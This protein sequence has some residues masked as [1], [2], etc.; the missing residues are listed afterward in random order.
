MLLSSL[1]VARVSEAPHAQRRQRRRCAA[2]A[3]A[4][5]RAAP[6]VASW[7]ARAADA[8][9][10]ASGADAPWNVGI[11]YTKRCVRPLRLLRCTIRPPVAQRRARVDGHKLRCVR[12][13]PCTARPVHRT[14]AIGGIP[15]ESMD[16]LVDQPSWDEVRELAHNRLT[17]RVCARLCHR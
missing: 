1:P 7:R 5:R 3:V 16:N 13:A 9:A 8:D 14:D 15:E 12:R 4:Q 6:Q 10:E 17:R 2:A 11:Y